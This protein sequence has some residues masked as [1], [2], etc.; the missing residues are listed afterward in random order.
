[1]R[2]DL[3]GLITDAS[4]VFVANR[5]STHGTGFAVDVGAGAVYK[6]WEVAFGA[7]G[8]SNRIDWN[9]VKQRTYT[10]ASLISG[11]SNFAGSATVLVSDTRVT[12]PVDYRGDVAYHSDR[13]SALGELGHGFGGT[14]F[15]GGGEFRVS[16]IELRGGGR[17]TVQKWNP[18]G[19]VGL[20]VSRRISFDVA[21]FG[22]NANVE[23]NHQAAIAASIRFNHIKKEVQPKG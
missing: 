11:N 14:S 4:N 18:T 21:V 19:G 8:I 7:K 1:L 9:T 3:S 23:R 17:Y 5:H 2:T 10:L 12:L 22:T 6:R 16:R 15:H 20:D 13:W